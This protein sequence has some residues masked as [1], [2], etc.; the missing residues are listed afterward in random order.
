M[1]LFLQ[2]F[3]SNG[4]FH[5][6]IKSPPSCKLEKK[7]VTNGKLITYIDVSGVFILSLSLPHIHTHTPTSAL[8]YGFCYFEAF[9]P[10]SSNM[11]IRAK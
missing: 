3:V 9:S 2:L 6:Y 1:Y 10:P 5:D 7:I 4:C 8:N 11:M